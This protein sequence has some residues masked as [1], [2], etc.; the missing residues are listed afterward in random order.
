MNNMQA[1]LEFLYVEQS[2]TEMMQKSW[3]LYETYRD[4]DEC[5][6]CDS[7]ATQAGEMEA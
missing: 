2:S 3:A 1:R 5:D 7:A 6:V 4:V